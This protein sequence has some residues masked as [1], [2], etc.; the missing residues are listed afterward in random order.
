MLLLVSYLFG[1]AAFRDGDGGSGRPRSCVSEAAAAAGTRSTKT[2]RKPTITS[3]SGKTFP[4]K[5][6]TVLFIFRYGFF[7]SERG[8]EISRNGTETDERARPAPEATSRS[9]A[10]KTYTYATDELTY[11]LFFFSLRMS[12]LVLCHITIITILITLYAA[13][14]R[15][16]GGLDDGDA[17]D[18]FSA[19]RVEK[20]PHH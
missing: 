17:A 10:R 1:S 19:K 16:G 15:A 8:G 11:F 4:R 20:N 5:S 12:A 13:V 14:T 9:T 2:S 3:S 7:P 18:R 6:T